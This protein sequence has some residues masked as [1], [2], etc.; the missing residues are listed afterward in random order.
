MHLAIYVMH[1]AI[2]VMHLADALGHPRPEPEQPSHE[3][4][5]PIQSSQATSS[6]LQECGGRVCGGL[7]IQESEIGGGRSGLSGFGFRA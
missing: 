5:Q 2:Y 7:Q 3:S 4:E 1:L 6:M